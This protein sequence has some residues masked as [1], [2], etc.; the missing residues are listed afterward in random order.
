MNIKKILKNK[1]KEE[2]IFLIK[3]KELESRINNVNLRR[4]LGNKDFI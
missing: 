3:E 2:R 4:K 1:I